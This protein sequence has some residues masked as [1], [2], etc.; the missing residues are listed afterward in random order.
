MLTFQISIPGSSLA[1]VPGGI[2]CPSGRGG[3]QLE[4]HAD[5]LRKQRGGEE[6]DSADRML[7]DVTRQE[8][9]RRNVRD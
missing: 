6:V 1:R 8:D 4:A 3:M 2:G 9:S 5:R 7:Q